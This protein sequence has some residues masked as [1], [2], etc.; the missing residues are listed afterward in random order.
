MVDEMV[1]EQSMRYGA[2]KGSYGKENIPTK[3]NPKRISEIR[4][5]KM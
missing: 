1:G 3:G 5:S 4:P 2:N